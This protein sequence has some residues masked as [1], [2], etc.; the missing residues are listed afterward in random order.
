ML[1][2][3]REAGLTEAPTI[4]FLHGGG[5][6]RAMWQPQLDRLR[7]YHCLAPDLLEQGNKSTT[8]H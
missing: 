1:L 7:E 4:V 2:Y 5:L 6:C 8:T 3:V